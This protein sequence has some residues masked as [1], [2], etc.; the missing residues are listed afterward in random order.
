MVCSMGLNL[1][2]VG[3]VLEVNVIMS[4]VCGIGLYLRKVGSELFS[5]LL[6]LPEMAMFSE[7]KKKYRIIFFARAP[8]LPDVWTLVTDYCFFFMKFMEHH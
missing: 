3:L 7:M 4:V 8:F 1:R 5:G 2:E 6:W